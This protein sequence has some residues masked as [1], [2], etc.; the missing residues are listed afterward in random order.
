MSG[1]RRKKMMIMGHP[2]S[3]KQG[4]DPDKFMPFAATCYFQL[5]LPE[6]SNIETM[7][8][9]F[10][11]AMANCKFIDGQLQFFFFFATTYHTF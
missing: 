6:Y 3:Q 11:Y 2:K 10:L 5:E 4:A 9:K 1:F 8:Q 7:Y